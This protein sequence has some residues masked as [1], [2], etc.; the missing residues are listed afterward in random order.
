MPQKPLSPTQIQALDLMLQGVTITEIAQQLGIGRS[1]IHEW[2][3][4]NSLFISAFHA[5]RQRHQAD[6]LDRVHALAAPSLNL[7][8]E[9]LQDPNVS[10]SVRLRAA[11]A[12]LK[13]VEINGPVYPFTPAQEAQLNAVIRP[14]AAAHAA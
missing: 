3:C 8:N 13:S 2:C 5:A 6:V 7:L 10:D 4:K 12:V 1:T 14:E 11:L 9:L